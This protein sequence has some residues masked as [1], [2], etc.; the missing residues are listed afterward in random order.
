MAKRDLPTPAELRKL[1]RYDATSGKLYWLPRVG[2]PGTVGA[3]NLRCAGREAFRIGAHGY[4]IGVINQRGVRAHRVVWAL[5]YGEWPRGE[6]DHIDGNKTNNTL[7]NLR[8]VSHA[9]NQRNQ[10]RPSHNSSGVIGVSWHKDKKRWCAHIKREGRQ[11]ALGSYRQFEEAV[12]AR[13][14]AE[15]EMGY[16]P[17]HGRSIPVPQ[18]A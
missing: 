2:D 17:N 9:V 7:S 15:V 4:L 18:M 14:R 1:L 11:V 8:V 12:V 6:V 13:A 5:V 3:F 16:H 10:R